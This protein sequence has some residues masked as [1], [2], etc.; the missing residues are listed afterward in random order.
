MRARRAWP[1]ISDSSRSS[2]VSVSWRPRGVTREPQELRFERAGTQSVSERYTALREGAQIVL[3]A[4]PPGGK[5]QELRY[6][7]HCR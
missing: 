3:A 1:R 5:A 2:R 7:V 4:K 6:Q